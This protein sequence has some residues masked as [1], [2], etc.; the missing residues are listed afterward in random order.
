[1][2]DEFK[3]GD[4]TV[5][6]WESDEEWS[7]SPHDVRII[8]MIYRRQRVHPGETWDQSILFVKNVF[9]SWHED[10]F[11]ALVYFEETSPNVETIPL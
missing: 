2:S 4:R 11:D 1:M 9:K 3:V 5:I 10:V 7:L 8:E 6:D